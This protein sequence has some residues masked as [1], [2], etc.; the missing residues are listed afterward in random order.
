MSLKRGQ[1]MSKVYDVKNLKIDSEFISLELSDITIKVPLIKTGSKILPKARLEHLQIFEIDDD[2]IGI[3]WPVLDED[4]SVAGLL[5]SA[6]R[7]D[8]VVEDIPSVYKD[9]CRTVYQEEM[10]LS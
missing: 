3:Y 10:N 4:L 5:R 1:Q 2:G 6:G 8:L 7:D 9:E